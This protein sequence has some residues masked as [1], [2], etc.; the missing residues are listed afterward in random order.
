MAHKYSASFDEIG[1]LLEEAADT[2]IFSFDIAPYDDFIAFMGEH[3]PTT[4]LQFGKRD[5]E[6]IAELRRLSVLA[7]S[8]E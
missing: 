8:M 2:G 5:P 6:F 3:S 1:Q 7:Y 4:K